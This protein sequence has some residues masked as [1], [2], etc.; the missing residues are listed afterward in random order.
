MIVLYDRDCGF[1]VWALGWVLRWDRWRRL[2]PV[3]LQ[4]PEGEAWLAHLPP[5]AR[6][7]SWHAVDEDGRVLSAGAALR[8]VLRCLP[9]GFVPAGLTR[10]APG[11]TGRTYAAVAANRSALARL[12]RSRAKARACALVAEREGV[13]RRRSCAEPRVCDPPAVP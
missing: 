7:A 4:G 2:R 11:L 12:L 10:L 8:E 6:L 9:G 5:H 1:C 13:Q 3:P